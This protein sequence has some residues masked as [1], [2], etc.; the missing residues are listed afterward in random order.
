MLKKKIYHV[1]NYII[2]INADYKLL[3]TEFFTTM[4]LSPGLISRNGIAGSKIKD[5]WLTSANIAKLPIHQQERDFDPVAKTLH[6]QCR[7]PG[8]DAFSNSAPHLFVVVSLLSRV[9]LFVTPWTVA[10][11]APLSVILPA[12]I[13]ERVAISF[14]GGSSRPRD[15][16]HVSC[17][18]RWI[19]YHWAAREVSPPSPSQTSVRP[20]HSPARTLHWLLVAD[21][22]VMD[23]EALSLTTERLWQ[24]EMGLEE[25]KGGELNLL[26]LQRHRLPM[27]RWIGDCTP[28][29][30]G[31]PELK[32][33]GP[34]CE[35]AGGPESNPCG[36]PGLNG[37]R[38]APQKIHELVRTCLLGFIP[39]EFSWLKSRL[40]V[41]LGTP[42]RPLSLRKHWPHARV[43]E[44]VLEERHPWDFCSQ[45]WASLR[46]REVEIRRPHLGLTAL[47]HA[48]VCRE[49]GRAW[50]RVTL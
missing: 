38:Q 37:G 11:Q 19:L 21:S 3:H 28:G 26:R 48:L 34:P 40:A 42:F 12:R 50:H 16:T 36:T 43:S 30:P 27:R 41:H 2:N 23:S 25:V 22:W 18:G 49:A 33:A 20:C 31:G 24:R 7:G 1:F 44:W 10:R 17:I 4:R 6:S 9:Q 39:P 15:Q 47:W 13:L 8:F 45:A 35:G 5:T 32:M 29:G 46:Q 14:C